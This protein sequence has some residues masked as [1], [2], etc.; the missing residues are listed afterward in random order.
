MHTGMSHFVEEE[1][2][3]FR[4]THSK[5]RGFNRACL[6]KPE[7]V[8]KPISSFL[9]HKYQVSLYWDLQQPHQKTR[10]NLRTS[11]LEL[12]HASKI[13]NT[14]LLLIILGLDFQSARSA[15]PP[16]APLGPLPV[17]CCQCWNMMDA[18]SVCSSAG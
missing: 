2:P 11:T 10:H 6:R 13:A 15:L 18:I 14:R 4:F 5:C 1:K 9:L 17:S 3:S 7:K 12:D 16:P 8:S